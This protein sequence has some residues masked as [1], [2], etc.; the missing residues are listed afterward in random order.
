M[1]DLKAFFLIKQTLVDLM[2][3]KY[4]KKAMIIETVVEIINIKPTHVEIIKIIK[5][6]YVEIIKIINTT[7]VWII[8]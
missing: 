5:P 3:V 7:H 2:R 8:I 1:Q 6:T 4:N